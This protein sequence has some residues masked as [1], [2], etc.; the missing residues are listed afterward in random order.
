[1]RLFRRVPDDD[2][3]EE[4]RSHVL[5]RADDLERSGLPRDEA[6]RRAR[7]ELGGALRYR[8]ECHDAA[9]GTGL[10]SLLQDTRYGL[11]VLRK[12]PTFTAVAVLTIALAIGANAVV[13]AALNA[14]ILRPLD[15]PDPGNLYSIHRIVGK[16]AAQSYPDYVD[17]RDRNTSFDGLAAFNFVIAGFDSGTNPLRSW[18]IAATG[19]Y[20]D[21]LRVQPYLGRL[22]HAD[23]EHGPNSASFVVL[24]HAFWH[25]H[26]HDDPSVIGR[27]V[28]LN[29]HPYTVIGVT[30]PGFHGTLLFF[31]GDFF[32]PLVNQEELTG[33]PFLAVRGDHVLFMALGRLKPGVTRDR[34]AADLDA[35]SA[36][37]E[38]DYPKDHKHAA[39][40]LARPNLYGDYVGGPARAF[41]TALMLLAGLILVAACANLG[42]LFA[43]RAADRTREIALRLALGAGRSRVVRQLLTEA[44]LISLAG[45]ALGLWGG[46][47]VMRWLVAWQPFPQYPINIPV[48][49]DARVYV[50]AA[51]LAL[52]SGLLFGAA[53]IRQVLRTDPYTV[54]KS[55][56]RTTVERGFSFRD[57]LVVAQIAICAVLVTASLV[58]VRGF[59]RSLHAAFGFEPRDVVL[60]ETILDMAGYRP[61]QVAPMQKR[62]MEAVATIPGVTSAAL[63]DWPPLATGGGNSPSVYSDS[64]SEFTARTAAASVLQLRVSPSYLATARTTLLAGR[65]FSEHDDAGAPRVAIVNTAFAQKLFGS[66]VAGLHAYFRLDEATRVQIVG[67]V[68]TGRYASLTEPPQAAMFLPL[69]QAPSSDTWL[70]VRSSTDLSIIATAIRDRL[71][72]LDA[73]LPVTIQSWDQ[74]M[75]L[76]RFPA[77]VATVSLGVLGIMGAMLSLSGV[78][79]MAAY[80]VS[81]RMRE[82]GIRM[83]LGAPRKSIVSAALGRA[84]RLLA[85]GSAAGV[86]LGLMGARVLASIV[87]QATPRDPLVVGGVLTVMVL[88]GLLATWIPAQRALSVDPLALLR[89]E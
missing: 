4:L 81:R 30:P 72:H 2:V 25:A 57:V 88:L 76:A 74:G 6:E 39:V 14:I 21:V 55:G 18:G 87:W 45:G 15:L 79:G 43:A 1:M 40:T 54:V 38:K 80:S 89:Q 84:L 11:R 49:P 59:M 9:G 70:V 37:L 66:A 69:L 10:E 73:A 47:I 46:L 56:P 61:D 26:F 32:V 64:A 23:D 83:A 71:H 78:F 19:N 34:A 20:F 58:A 28:Q 17:L 50:A 52:A 3:D 36:Q 75:D 33:T 62:M 5:L 48:N 53:P 31:S 8:E 67:I 27:V 68:E 85:L 60:A 16:S 24:T 77:R 7:I 82:F 65:M 51:L 41:L 29:K 13:F 42:S 22:F 63:V 86:A 44:M 35:I 12:A